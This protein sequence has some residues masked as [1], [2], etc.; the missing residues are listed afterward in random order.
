MAEAI[1]VLNNLARFLVVLGGGAA[2]VFLVMSG[3]LYLGAM[4]EAQGIAKARRAFFGA[5]IGMLLCGSS[6]I[7]PQAVARFVIEPAGGFVRYDGPGRSCDADL[8]LLLVL[9]RDVTTGT[10]MNNMI[11]II[12]SRRGDCVVGRWDPVVVNLPGT[13]GGDDCVNE[14]CVFRGRSIVAG[15]YRDKSGGDADCGGW[16]Y[17][18][19]ND[20]PHRVVPVGVNVERSY[21][22]YSGHIVVNFKQKQ[23]GISER[24][25]SDR[26][27]CWVYRSDLNSWFG[28]YV[29]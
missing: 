24:L 3:V 16:E 25:P 22:S 17:L 10:D 5:V 23:P 2:V 21:K 27:M 4:G 19:G 13:L 15:S 7:I 14:D 1:T 28:Q 8:R 12:Q 6:F 29:K 26:A 11:R 18:G 20:E 9:N